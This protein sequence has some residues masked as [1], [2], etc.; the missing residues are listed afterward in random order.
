MHLIKDSNL[1]TVGAENAIN[2]SIVTILL[3][4][5]G[6]YFNSKTRFIDILNTAF[7]YRFP[8]YIVA[9]LSYLLIPK[10]IEERIV[11]NLKTPENIFTNPLEIIMSLVLGIAIMLCLTYSI[12]LLVNGF[13]TA[14]NTKKWQHWV[15]F[16]FIILITEGITQFLIKQLL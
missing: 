14:T 5:L 9:V 8:I 3:F 7:W 16:G 6:K 15:A 13:K 11:K 4:A 10:N 1:A 2:I 12:V